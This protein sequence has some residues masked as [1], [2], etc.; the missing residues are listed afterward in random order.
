MAPAT[1][2]Q[3]KVTDPAAM[4]LPLAGEE[5]DGAAVGQLTSAEN[6]AC[7]ES[8]D[9]QPSAFARTNQ[10]YAAALRLTEA[11][12]PVEV[13]TTLKLVPSVESSTS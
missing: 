3:E 4:L 11:E 2:V 6:F 13:A 8:I 5:I 7:V 1:D 9:L 10:T 12:V